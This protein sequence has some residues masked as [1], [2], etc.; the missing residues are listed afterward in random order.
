[1][2]DHNPEHLAAQRLAAAGTDFQAL[3]EIVAK[4]R[5]EPQPERL[6]LHR[7][8][9]RDRDNA[10][11]QPPG[12]RR[13]RLPAARAARRVR[14]GCDASRRSG[15]GCGCRWCWRRSARWKAFT[16]GA[17]TSVVRAAREFGVAHMLSSVCEPGLEKVAEAAPDGCRIFQLYV[18]GDEAWVDDHVARAHRQRLRGVLHHG[19]HRDLQPARAR[20]RQA[21]RGGGPPARHR[22]RV[23]GGARLAHRQA[24]Q[25]ASST[26][27]WPSRASRPPRTPGSRSITASSGSTSPITAAASSTTAAAPWRCC[28]RSSR[29]SPDA[30]AIIV[31]GGFARGTDIVKALA[32][33]AN[34]VGLGRMQCYRAGGGRRGGA[35]AHARNPRRRGAALSRPARGDEIRRA[36]PLLS[37]RRRRP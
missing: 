19:R 8:R 2:Q 36:R 11:P 29:R 21:P 34:L 23:P 15:G 14:R 25:G 32:T 4:A 18:R 16:S 20:H 35:G 9:H 33:G 12:A 17:A 3:H 26:F 5:A 10:A 13:P 37:A 30:P 1:M 31:D 28:R 24:H 7:R 27:R 22:P 6:G